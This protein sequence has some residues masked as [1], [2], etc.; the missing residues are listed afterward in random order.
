MSRIPGAT[1]VV[2][3]VTKSFRR[4]LGG[5]HVVLRDLDLEAK[6]GALVLVEGSP[7]SGRSTLLRCLF[8][9]YWIDSGSVVIKSDVGSVD[10]AKTSDRAVAWLRERYV[11]FF[12][13]QLQAPPHLPAWRV[14]ARSTG[15]AEPAVRERLQS[16]GLDQCRDLAIGRL[17]TAEARAFALATALSRNTSIYLLDDPL[18]GQEGAVH[19]QMTAAI[20]ALLER[21]AAVIVTGPE[22]G[23]LT[24]IATWIH[25]LEKPEEH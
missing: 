7:G 3:G 4:E 15:L 14:V 5:S 9:T 11:S 19:D 20:G 16:F 25:R 6:P 8:G 22:G 23:P 2:D 21:D 24:S 13:G 12:D 18:F 1:L 10:L 17:R